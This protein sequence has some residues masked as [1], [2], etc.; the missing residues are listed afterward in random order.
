MSDEKESKK[1]KQLSNTKALKVVTLR[2]KF[3]YMGYRGSLLVFFVS[4]CMFILSLIFVYIFSTQPVAPLYIPI[5]ENGSYIDLVR[6]DQPNKN[7]QEVA[8]FVAKAVKKLYTRDYINYSD[9]L[10]DASIY[11]TP[12]GFNSF[13]DSVEASQSI[14]A[15]KQNEWVV[16]FTPRQAPILLEKKLNGNAYTWAFDFPGTIT[17]NGGKS[18]RKQ[19]VTLKIIVTRVSIVDSPYGIGITTLVPF[20]DK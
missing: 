18:G 8:D 15:M 16:S 4:L 13:L 2:N 5:K 20:D 3:F 6:I 1:N 10:M 11:F 12:N 7:D 19:N 14:A 17:Y 9:Q